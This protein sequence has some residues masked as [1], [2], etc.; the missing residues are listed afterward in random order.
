MAELRTGDW[1]SGNY[2]FVHN[3]QP[4]PLVR[5]QPDPELAPDPAVDKSVSFG[6]FSGKGISFIPTMKMDCSKITMDR[7]LQEFNRAVPGFGNEARFFVGLEETDPTALIPGQPYSVYPRKIKRPAENK[8]N[9]S[10][11]IQVSRIEG[12]LVGIQWKVSD[13]SGRQLCL[14][15]TCRV[16]EEISLLQLFKI[17]ITPKFRIQGIQIMWGN[18]YRG[19]DIL[20]IG[21]VSS[22]EEGDLVE[23]VV[24]QGTAPQPTQVDVEYEIEDKKF[25]IFVEGTMTI[26]QLRQRLNH[27]H[28]GKGITAIASEG[29]PIHEADPVEDWI[30]RTAGI[31]LTAVLPK[32]VQ[33]IVDFRGTFKHF[34]VQ[35]DVAEDGFK[36]LV[37]QFVGLKPGIHIAVV[38]LGL[39]SREI[40]AGTTYWERRRGR[41]R[42][43]RRTRLMAGL[44]SNFQEI[45]HW[46][47]PVKSSSTSGTFRTGT[48]SRSNARTMHH[49]GLNQMVNITSPFATTLP[50]I[51]GPNAQSKS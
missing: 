7:M 3:S 15:G 25:K 51:L 24:D 14:P 23:I 33:V 41:W 38:P 42:F 10:G 8:A 26:E 11:A 49:F 50:K 31:P 12:P 47:K 43:G 37:K 19:G 30:Q 32:T 2:S 9:P 20:E 22:L 29:S 1:I 6:V 13:L 18:H 45:Q 34:A 16:P 5:A 48:K 35:D 44:I 36:S 21:K 28:K 40:R 27:D 46:T 4:A 17:F 39:S